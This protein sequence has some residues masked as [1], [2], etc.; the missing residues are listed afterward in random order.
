TT[1]RRWPRCCRRCVRMRRPPL[2]FPDNSWEPAMPAA[3]ALLERLSITLPIF[4]GP[5]TGSDT[6]QLAAAVSAAGGLGM[7]GCGM[8]SPQAMHEAAAAVRAATDRP[9]GMNLFVLQ[10]PSP[11]E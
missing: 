6:P 7:L 3:H 2:P 5:M 8:R 4:Q 11:D 9:F 1:R 10:A